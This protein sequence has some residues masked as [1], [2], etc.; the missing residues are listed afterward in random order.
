[1]SS[2]G[3]C[4]GNLPKAVLLRSGVHK[5]KEILAY[6]SWKGSWS[7]S[8]PKL[9]FQTGKLWPKENPGLPTHGS[10]TLGYT[11]LPREAMTPKPGSSWSIGEEMEGGSGRTMK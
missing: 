5:K 4:F 10:I 3:L 8:N 1:M 9:I 7:S 11:P 2:Q 6:G